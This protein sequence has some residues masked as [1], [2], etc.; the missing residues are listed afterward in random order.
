MFTFCPPGPGARTKRH[1]RSCARIASG[2]GTRIMGGSGE[3]VVAEDARTSFTRGLGAA[4]P[5]SQLV[6]HFLGDVS[7]FYGRVRE[8]RVRPALGWVAS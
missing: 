7:L 2:S 8:S 3:G 5:A 4:G 6:Y 1:P